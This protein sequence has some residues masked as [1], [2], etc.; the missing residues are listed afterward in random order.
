MA[1]KGWLLLLLLPTLAN[2]FVL[3]NQH[4]QLEV[5]VPPHQICQQK[6]VN[7]FRG[8]VMNES[9]FEVC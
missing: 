9:S 1:G 8:K 7:K 2:S 6:I 3:P 4:M 5:N